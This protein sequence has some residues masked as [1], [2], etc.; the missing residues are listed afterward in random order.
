MD[1]RQS[2]RIRAEES[3]EVGQVRQIAGFERSGQFTLAAAIM[4]QHQQFD[5]DLAG[6]LVGKMLDEG[7]KG[8]AILLTWD[9]SNSAAA[10]GR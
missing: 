3:S 8:P 5:G 10:A 7:L 6:L 4:G 2:F 9:E 1:G